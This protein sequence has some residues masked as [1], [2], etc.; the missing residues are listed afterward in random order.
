MRGVAG[1]ATVEHRAMGSPESFVLRPQHVRRLEA[2]LGIQVLGKRRAERAR[3][4][5]CFGIDR[6]GFAAISLT[7]PRVDEGHATQ[8][9]DLVEIKRAIAVWR[10]GAKR[11][12]L[13]AGRICR[14]RSSPRSE[15]AV[16][17][18]L[19]A[20]PEVAQEKPQ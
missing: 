18:G 15:P 1:R 14:Q 19:G 16:E 7:G 5:A 4:V 9:A 2:A 8:P 20:M 11:T 3:N 13:D 17:H 12:A 6:L 10:L